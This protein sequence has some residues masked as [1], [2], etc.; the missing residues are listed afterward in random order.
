MA[1]TGLMNGTFPA[2]K[3]AMTAVPGPRELGIGEGPITVASS[4]RMGR[5]KLVRPG[6][7]SVAR[8]TSPI[9]A[10]IMVNTRRAAVSPALPATGA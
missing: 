4:R 8:M 7:S 10:H 9:R 1:Q 2:H 3:T 6:P 5:L